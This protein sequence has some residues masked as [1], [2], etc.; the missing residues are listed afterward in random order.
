MRTAPWWNVSPTIPMGKRRN[1]DWTDGAVTATETPRGFTGHEHLEDLGLVHMNGRVYDPT[2][3]RFISADPHV[4]FPDSTQGLN[5]Y[6]YVQQQ[7][8]ELYGPDGVF[9]QE[10]L[11]GGEEA[12]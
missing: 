9:L 10:T 5:R 3:G 1:A 4:Q 8:V 2:L 12:V 11:Q 7:S 6:S